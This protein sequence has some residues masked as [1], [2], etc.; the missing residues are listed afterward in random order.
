MTWQTLSPILIAA[1]LLGGCKTL[2]FREADPEKYMAYDCEQLGQLA[3]SFRPLTQEIV[4]ADRSELE[5]RN[6]GSRNVGLRDDPRPY[7]VGQDRERR[8]IAL[9]RRKKGCM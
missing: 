6:E 2:D 4:F 5:R 8:S 9:A 1:A 3:E 7:E